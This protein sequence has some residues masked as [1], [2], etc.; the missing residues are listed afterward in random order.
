LEIRGN[1]SARDT[2]ERGKMIKKSSLKK[3]GSIVEKGVKSSK[4][5]V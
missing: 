5:N 1:I 3:R 2:K 4:N